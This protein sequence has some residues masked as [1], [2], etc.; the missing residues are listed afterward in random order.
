MCGRF[1]LAVEK[2]ILEMLF[3]LELRWDLAPGYNIAPSREILAVR[4]NDSFRKEFARLKWGLV[5]SWS[6][7]ASGGYKMIN[8]RAETVAVKPAFRDAFFKRRALV[9]VSGFFEWKKENHKK[10]PYYIRIRDEDPFLIGA[11]WETWRGKDSVTESCALLTTAANST[12]A[13]VHHRMPLI[14]SRELSGRW[15]DPGAGPD[16]LQEMIRPYGSDGRMIIHPVSRLVNN[17]A[18]DSPAC[19]KE[20]NEIYKGN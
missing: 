19:I 12:L 17:P 6:K 1:A 4:L 5:P 13:A 7:E 14:I 2:Q 3:D 11:L 18:N 16:E 9:P 20:L 10:Q 8:A 15:L